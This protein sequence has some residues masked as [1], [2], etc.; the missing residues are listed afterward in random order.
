MIGKGVPLASG[1][2]RGKGALPLLSLKAAAAP[3][4]DSGVL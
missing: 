1:L 4:H 3:L 2:E